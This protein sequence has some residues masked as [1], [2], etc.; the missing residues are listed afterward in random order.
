MVIHGGID[1]FS[2]LIV[3]M[4]CAINNTAITVLSQFEA[5]ISTYGYPCSVY[6]N[7]GGENVDVWCH[8]LQW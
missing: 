4:K 7:L 5:A 2:L 3:Y 6:S 1:G 8:M